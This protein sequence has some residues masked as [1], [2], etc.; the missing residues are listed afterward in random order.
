FSHRT[1]ATPGFTVWSHPSV[2]A[3]SRWLSSEHD[4]AGGRKSA[5]PTAI[6][7]ERAF[8]TPAWQGIPRKSPRCLLSPK[9]GTMCP[10]AD[11]FNWSIVACPWMKSRTCFRNQQPIDRRDAF[12]LLSPYL[13]W[14][15]LSHPC[16]LGTSDSW[17][18]QDSS[19]ASSEVMTSDILLV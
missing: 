14:G 17:P 10:L 7:P 16:I 1:S 3:I 11:R 19:T 2:C 6:S 9:R 18:V 13:P 12:S 5:S 15:G 8:I 4:E